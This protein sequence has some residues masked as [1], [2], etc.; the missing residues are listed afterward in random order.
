MTHR[1]DQIAAQMHR[2][3]S[4]ELARGLNDARIRGLVSVTRVTLSP[5]LAEATVGISVLPA[6]HAELTMHGLRSA[7]GLLQRALGRAVRMRRLPRLILELDRSLQRLAEIDDA[8][9]AARNA[10]NDSST[11][12][13]NT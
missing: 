3:I 6:E 9:A 11:Q 8:L 2:V 7:T 12:E 13:E 4:Q 10:G 1:T 5:D